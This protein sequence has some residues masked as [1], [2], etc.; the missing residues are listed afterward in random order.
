MEGYDEKTRDQLITE[1][2]SLCTRI[3]ILESHDRERMQIDRKL[4]FVLEESFDGIGMTDERGIIVEWNSA[5]AEMTGIMR[6]QA[7]GKTVRDI[8]AS[9][10]PERYRSNPELCCQIE[11]ALR[12]APGNDE[13]LLLNKPKE[14]PV[15]NPDKGLRIIQ[16]KAVPVPRGNGSIT[17]E[18][19]GD[20]NLSQANTYNRNL[21]EAFPDP[22]IVLT[23]EGVIRKMNTAAERMTGY[24]REEGIGTECSRY[25]TTPELVKAGI[26]RILRKDEIRNYELE[27]IRCD[28]IIIPVLCH[29]SPLRDETGR[30]TGFIATGRDIS[31]RKKAEVDR[32]R[33]IEM[34]SLFN[35]GGSTRDLM[36]ALTP[37][38]RDWTGC[39]AA[40]IRLREGDDFPYY[41]TC[42]FPE[43][44]VLLESRLCVQD[45]EGKAMR[46]DIGNPALEC[47]CGN[48][49]RGRFDPTKPFFT[50]H[51][52]F[53]TNSTT[54]LLSS[55][56]ETDRQ[57]RT[58][59]RCNGEGYESVALIPLRHTGETFGLL[60]FNDRR[61]N[62]FTPELIAFLETIG[63][64]IA[65]ALSAH[66]LEEQF[67]EQKNFYE[68]ILETTAESVLITNRSDIICYANRSTETMAGTPREQIEGSNVLWNFPEE[69]LRFFRPM[70]QKARESL[71]PFFCDPIPVVTP[72]GRPSYQSGW[73]VPKVANGQFDGMIC[74]FNDVTEQLKLEEEIQKSRKLESI[75]V[76]A[77]GIA[78]NFNNILTTILG[79]ITLAKMDTPPE[80][81]RYT[82]LQ[83][84]ESAVIRAKELTCRLIT[85]SH[86]GKPMLEEI[87]I[88]PLI[89]EISH[90][91]LQESGIRCHYSIP[92][93]LC[94]VEI[95][96]QQIRQ[97]IAGI[98]SNARE[99]MCGEGEMG[100][101]AEE[102]VINENDPLPVRPG[103]YI[104][105]M[106]KDSGPGIPSEFSARLFDPFF[107]TKPGHDGLGLTT[108]FSII[109][110][111]EGYITAES[112]REGGAIFSVYLPVR[113]FSGNSDK[114]QLRF[115]P[116]ER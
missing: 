107:S 64:N 77:G 48:I 43:E 102:I 28:G 2:E 105:I 47:M 62:R 39:E 54:E 38:L 96:Q 65:I 5:A 79:G 81:E 83:E 114:K 6:N 99:A 82:A 45:Q 76:L 9:M 88:V 40:G 27:I 12:N 116:G 68:S 35:R 25:F 98:V 59:N 17:G 70:Y 58:R 34:L 91:V 33:T 26:A 46:D 73:L 7:L 24:S 84:S 21:F 56:S 86:G 103:R 20:I 53:W 66:R 14:M 67:R 93:S 87:S 110:N 97:V 80:D 89:R 11:D 10:P 30:V 51:G 109:R 100:I 78:H 108:S 37:R 57:S 44:F 32:E 101:S 74:T 94:P 15:I 19:L 75:G 55:T 61:K 1:L 111:H 72:T 36:R 50:P 41:E 115:V 85:F 63:D 104:R 113:E 71:R 52:S 31:D 4:R 3:S 106:V 92:D 42:G 18:N 29:T 60:Q 8:F 112:G 13:T 23:P 95:D 22:I 90:A 69:T 49:L 16:R